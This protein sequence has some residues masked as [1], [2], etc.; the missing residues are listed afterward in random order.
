[1]KVVVTHVD[2]SP[3]QKQSETYKNVELESSSAAPNKQQSIKSLCFLAKSF[4]A[5]ETTLYYQVLGYR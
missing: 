1:M 4:K 3:P 5:V 2:T